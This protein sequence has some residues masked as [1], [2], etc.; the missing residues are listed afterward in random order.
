MDQR[1]YTP[2]F[3]PEPNRTRLLAR[4]L[5]RWDGRTG[6]RQSSIRFA[7][8]RAARFLWFELL[9][10]PTVHGI[11]LEFRSLAGRIGT[12]YATNLY[13]RG[14]CFGGLGSYK[15]QTSN[16]RTLACK[17]DTQR[18]ATEHRWATLLDLAV[19]VEAWKAGAEWA[20]SSGR[21]EEVDSI[22]K[23]LQP[24]AAPT[25]ATMTGCTRVAPES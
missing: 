18:I 2:A 15:D 24:C 12:I 8:S 4:W 21:R 14:V 10:A 1:D 9:S 13:R 6:K 5:W 11:A 20:A 16:E 22:D 7:V 25:P 23:L 19:Y 3:F 17:R